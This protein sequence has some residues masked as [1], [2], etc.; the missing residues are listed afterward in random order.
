MV[1]GDT[2]AHLKNKLDTLGKELQNPFKHIRNW[3]KGEVMNL[4]SLMA[5][6]GEK[7]S[8]DVRKQAAVKKLCADREL[9]MKLSEGKF[10]IKAAF[11]SKSGKARQQQ[12][13]LERIAQRQRD[14]E[15]WDKIKRFLTVYLAEI[16]IPDF[17]KKKVQKYITCMSNF[18]NDELINAKKHQG[19]WGDFYDL[20]TAYAKN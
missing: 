3:I 16:A 8:C 10:T 2:K 1:S 19:C 6:I 11:K 7:E 13:V 18:S 15:N 5:A 12:E 17:K 14:I 20:T 4:E 9:N